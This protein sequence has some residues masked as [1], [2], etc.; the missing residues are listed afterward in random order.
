MIYLQM[1]GMLPTPAEIY[2]KIKFSVSFVKTSTTA[3]SMIT[4]Y[5][6]PLPSHSPE[7]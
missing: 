7:I 4:L 2:Q 1:V 3:I 5:L 6:F